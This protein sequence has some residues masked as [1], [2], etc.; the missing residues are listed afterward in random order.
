MSNSFFSF[1]GIVQRN[2]GRGRELGY[3]TANI[4]ITQDISEGLY[5]G[6]A[7]LDA[8]KYPSLIFIGPSRTF[9]E[10]DKKAEIYILNFSKD[11]YG[12]HL[13]VDI[14]QKIRENIKFNSKEELIIQMKKR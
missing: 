12:Q 1:S 8:I 14:I 10:T 6:Y 11:I 13:I 3:P 4:S 9:N 2:L 7:T 5:I